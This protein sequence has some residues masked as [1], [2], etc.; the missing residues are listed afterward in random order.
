MFFILLGAFAVKNIAE[1]QEQHTFGFPMTMT[2]ILTLEGDSQ[3]YCRMITF[4]ATGLGWP[5]EED[6]SPA[7]FPWPAPSFQSLPDGG[8][9]GFKTKASSAEG[10]RP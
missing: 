8:W 7:F 3:K 4:Y 1:H 6:T 10:S 5:E 9:P 2:I